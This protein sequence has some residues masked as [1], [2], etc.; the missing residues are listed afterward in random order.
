MVE[1]PILNTPLQ[2]LR[3]ASIL[4][5]ALVVRY[6]L[7]AGLFYWYYY[8]A[9]KN[10]YTP[11]SKMQQ[12]KSQI[13]KEINWS[14]QSSV[15]FAIIGTLAYWLWQ[16]GFTAIYLQINQ[17]PLWYLPVS[18]LIYSLIH[19]TYY[20]WVHRA[21][22]IPVLYKLM[23]RQHH[24]SIAPSPFTAFSFH[25]LEALVEAL[26]LPALLLIIPIH[27][28]VLGF[29]LLLMTVSSVINHL[30]IE[31]YPEWLQKSWL[32]KLL[33]G[34]THHHYHHA[35]FTTNYGLYYTFWDEWMGTE[36]KHNA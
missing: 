5:F 1:L 2:F 24:S 7:S 3:F 15:V 35:E 10:D 33:I 25:P 13:F 18:L 34:A 27:P 9:K 19:E 36:S 32:G 26:I 21:M 17:F 4:L 14:I 6:F 16:N 22:H 8:K 12:G 29:Y 30:D 23:H 31:I 28:I 20:Y 11:L